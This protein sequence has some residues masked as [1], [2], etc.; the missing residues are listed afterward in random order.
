VLTTA[1][2]GQPDRFLP[3]VCGGYGVVSDVAGHGLNIRSVLDW[4]ALTGWDCLGSA[5]LDRNLSRMPPQTSDENPKD[6]LSVAVLGSDAVLAALPAHPIQLTHACHQLGFHAV[7]PLSWGD[8]LIAEHVLRELKTRGRSPVVMCS[9]ER[10]RTRLLSSGV[11]LGRFLVSTVT[12]AVAVGRYLRSLY[13]GRRIRLTFVGSCEGGAD[14]VFDDQIAPANLLRMFANAS[15]DLVDQPTHF[16]AVVPPDRRRHASL[17]NGCPT[18]EVLRERGLHHGLAEIETG[19]FVSQLAEFLLAH[20]PV[21]VDVA[22]ALGCACAGS[23]GMVAP[24]AARIAVMSLEPPR[25]SAS[26]LVLNPAVDVSLSATSRITRTSTLE[27]QRISELQVTAGSAQSHSADVS[28]PPVIPA[29]RPPAVTP[30]RALAAM[31]SSPIWASRSRATQSPE[32]VGSPIPIEGAALV[33]ALADDEPVR[34]HHD[35]SIVPPA[36][37]ARSVSPEPVERAEIGSGG[38]AVVEDSAKPAAPL[39]RPALSVR[40]VPPP[41]ARSRTAFYLGCLAVLLAIAVAVAVILRY[42]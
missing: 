42:R 6:V 2:S 25:A 19:D 21:L 8:E 16:S 40:R 20:D 11:E 7:V 22:P 3:V 18:S 39:S 29:R 4:T 5:G 38:A 27:R 23:G 41:Q 35:E 33:S 30:P 12:P 13:E 17:P 24:N 14:E 37:L 9:C 26:P 31:R 10:V 32:I 34:V 1:G 28:P 15:I 36:L